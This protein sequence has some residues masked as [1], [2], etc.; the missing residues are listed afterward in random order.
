[1]K[2][3]TLL[4][5]L[6]FYENALQELG[7]SLLLSNQ[8]NRWCPADTLR[9]NGVLCFYRLTHQC[10][11]FCLCFRQG[12]QDSIQPCCCVKEKQDVSLAHRSV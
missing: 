10:V 11:F 3:I 6:T 8:E 7:V 5:Y 4:I 9:I 12:V 1:M 2:L